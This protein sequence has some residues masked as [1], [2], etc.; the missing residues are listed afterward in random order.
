MLTTVK[1][2]RIFFEKEALDYPLGKEIYDRMRKEGFNINFLKS[3]NRV[4]GIPGKNPR[5]AF[6]QG[7]STLVVGIR[8]NLQFETCK[9][10]AHYQLPLVTGCEGICEYCYLNTQ[11]GKKPY[12]RIYVNVDEILNEAK[13]YIEKRKPEITVF[14]AA[15]TSDPVAVEPYSGALGY[16]IKFFAGEEYGRLRFVTKFPYVDSFLPLTHNKHTRIRFSLNTERIIKTYEH[17][18]PNLEERLAGLKKI[19]EHGYPGGVIIAPVILEE[20]W[21]TE[22]EDLLYKMQAYL[23]DIDISDFRLEIISHRF[24]TRAKNNILQVFP[25]TLLPMDEKTDRKFKYGQFGYGKFVYTDEKLNDM[26]VFFTEK[27]NQLL[28]GAVIDYII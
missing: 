8:K 14:E 16:A 27:I 18:T 17:R 13:K 26:K 7:K 5:E 20:N 25:Q 4:T 22:Y 19:A 2:K 23:Q 15:A 24:T 21:K 12:T 6:F 10:S 1:F 3:H 11:L 28:P 9:P